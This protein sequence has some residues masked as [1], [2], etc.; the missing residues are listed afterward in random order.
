MNGTFVLPGPETLVVFGVHIKIFSAIFGL[1]GCGLGH[2]MAPAAVE[3]LGWRRHL[4]VISAGMF[5]AIAITI[6]TGQR[7]LLVFGWSIGIGFAGI[8]LFKGWAAQA[9][10]AAKTLGSAALD[11]LSERLAARKDKA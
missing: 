11:E 8:T 10:A 1:A 2:I 7:P 6:A 4:G 9:Q 3:P 5:V